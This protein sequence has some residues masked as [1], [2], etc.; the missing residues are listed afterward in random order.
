MQDLEVV[1]AAALHQDGAQYIKN[2]IQIRKLTRWYWL[3]L[4]KNSPCVKE[5]LGTFTCCFKA[6]FRYLSVTTN[7]PAEG[8]LGE[9]CFSETALQTDGLYECLHTKIIKSWANNSKNE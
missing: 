9:R 1:T 2:K 4:Q 6:A 3:L 7:M 8:E 5:K